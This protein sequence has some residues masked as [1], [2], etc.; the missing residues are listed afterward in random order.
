MKVSKRIKRIVAICLFLAVS[1]SMCGCSTM[2]IFK[3]DDRTVDDYKKEAT[4]LSYYLIRRMFIA[5]Y[6][7]VNSYVN[8]SDRGEV[9]T[10]VLSLDTGLYKDADVAISAINIDEETYSTTIEYRITLTFER[11]TKA[12]LCKMRMTRSGSS[13]RIANAIPFCSDLQKINDAYINGKKIDEQY[14][15]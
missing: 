9:K 15:I 12:F 3:K 13:W 8:K 4:E 5:D 6:D 11:D 7:S 1:I 14:R 10:A 2:S